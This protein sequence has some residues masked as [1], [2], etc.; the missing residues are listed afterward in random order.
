MTRTDCRPDPPVIGTSARRPGALSASLV[1]SGYSEVS[2]TSV[3]FGLLN[4]FIESTT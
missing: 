1:V 3:R 4:V 2:R